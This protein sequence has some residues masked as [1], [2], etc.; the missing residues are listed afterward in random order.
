MD[1]HYG[2]DSPLKIL[3]NKVEEDLSDKEEY[4]TFDNALIGENIG[5]HTFSP[6]DENSQLIFPLSNTFGMSLFNQTEDGSF[7]DQASFRDYIN[8]ISLQ[9]QNGNS[10]VGFD[11][12]STFVRLNY[13]SK[14]DTVFKDFSFRGSYHFNRV[15]SDKTGTLLSNLT[16]DKSQIISDNSG[17]QSFLQASTRLNTKLD[18]T[19][20][21]AFLEKRDVAVYRA[22][23]EVTASSVS[24]FDNPDGLFIYSSNNTNAEI[25]NDLLAVNA[26]SNYVLISGGKYTFDITD[27]L[28]RVISNLTELEDFMLSVSPNGH[29]VDQLVI[30]NPKKNIAIKIYYTEL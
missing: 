22:E 21:K 27:Y 6:S 5:E 24:S 20:I 29:R 13:T 11:Y 10:I 2:D 18:F 3:V 15:I 25:T 14:G 8:G 19:S 17:D 7:K 16:S 12:D 23:L 30:N 4:Y 26:S 9:P 28:Q 1:Y